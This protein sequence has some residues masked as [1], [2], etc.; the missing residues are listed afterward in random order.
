MGS[1]FTHAN[2]LAALL[3]AE[4]L[5]FA[6][7]TVGVALSAGGALGVRRVIPPQLMAIASTTILFLIA[8]GALTA[9]WDIYMES[10]PDTFGGSAQ[11]V[12]IAVAVAAQPLFA[13][14]IALNLRS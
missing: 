13:A 4:S 11:A 1:S 9:W 8:F 10:W 7:T 2:A 6:A 5:L 3:T 14:A 12:C